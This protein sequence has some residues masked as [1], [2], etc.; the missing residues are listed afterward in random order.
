MPKPSDDWLKMAKEFQTKWNFPH[1]LGP[2]DGKNIA[3]HAPHH[4]GSKF[5]NYKNF[6]GIVLMALVDADY[7]C[8]Y[9][10]VS[11]NGRISDGRV[12]AGCSLDGRLANV[13]ADAP[14]QMMKRRCCS[15]IKVCLS[16]T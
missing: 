8:I 14:L 6:H 1:I 11:C 16:V 9:I 12:F 2:P 13:T 3:L 5:Y 10:D 4:A 7:K 15:M